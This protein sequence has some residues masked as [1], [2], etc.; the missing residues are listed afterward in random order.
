[1]RRN[2]ERWLACLV[3]LLALSAVELYAQS[4]TGRISGTVTDASGAV[5]PG[6]TVSV[7]QEG[8]GLTRSAIADEKG[9]YVFVSLPT[10]AYTVA[11]ELS[12]F[13]KA[14]RSGYTLV[15]DG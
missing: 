7:T 4:T 11:A 9:A 2:L 10:G 12:G 1:M 13:Q 8:T 6:A 14:V 15:A 3:T 5:L